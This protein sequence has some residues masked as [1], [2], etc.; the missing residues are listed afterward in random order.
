MTRILA[1]VADVINFLLAGELPSPR[2][3]VLQDRVQLDA[4]QPLGS[5]ALIPS[6]WH[7][8]AERLLVK[9]GSP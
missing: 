7:H 3:E 8:L 9:A 6:T 1:V 5:L 2:G 4:L